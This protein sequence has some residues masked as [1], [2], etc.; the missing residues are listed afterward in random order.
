MNR[1]TDTPGTAGGVEL[2]TTKEAAA[3]LKV[4]EQTLMAQRVRGGGPPFIKLGNG[5]KAAVRYNLS[6][7]VLWLEE[8]GRE[9][10]A[11]VEVRK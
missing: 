11:Q 9:N 6:K 7:V 5:P 8:Q 10:T 3:F 4:S 2:L 1:H